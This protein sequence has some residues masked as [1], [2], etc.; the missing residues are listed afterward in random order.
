MAA[1]VHQAR[2]WSC[3]ESQNFQKIKDEREISTREIATMLLIVY[4]KRSVL[5]HGVLGGVAVDP[6]TLWKYKYSGTAVRR[7]LFKFQKILSGPSFLWLTCSSHTFG[8]V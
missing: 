7:V 8:G 3:I 6:S 4:N 5:Q 1:S 2:N